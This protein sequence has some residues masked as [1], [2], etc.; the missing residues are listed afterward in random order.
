[1]QEV[2]RGFL[3]YKSVRPLSDNWRRVCCR[4]DRRVL[5]D[6]RNDIKGM[7]REFLPRRKYIRKPSGSDIQA[8]YALHEEKHGLPGMLSSIDYMHWYWNNCPFHVNSI[9]VII[10]DLI[11]ETVASHDQWIWHA[12]FGV[13]GAMND[14]IVVNL[15]PIFNDLFEDKAPD[16][17]F[18][19]NGTNYKHEY[20]LAN[21]IYPDTQRTRDESSP[22]NAN[23]QLGKTLNGHSPQF[24]KNDTLLVDGASMDT[25]EIEETMYACIIL[26]NMICEYEGFSH[27][28]FDETEVLVEDI[29]TNISEENRAINWKADVA[30]AWQ[31]VPLAAG[32]T[33]VD[34]LIRPSALGP[35]WRPVPPFIALLD[36]C[37]KTT[38]R[39]QIS[40][41]ENRNRDQTTSSVMVTAIDGG[42]I[43]KPP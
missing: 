12:F 5:E 36:F 2:L 4:F 31:L 9:E 15:S 10:L 23:N 33:I 22:R 30:L 1:M 16:S 8:I 6:G 42:G 43:E 18:V 11:L 21:G 32:K 29:E 13:S 39:N 19:V 40:I 3:Y 34:G 17:S 7:P 20:Y 28:H 14:I 24:K 37:Y 25:K 38:N 41:A 26:H 27:Y 35:V